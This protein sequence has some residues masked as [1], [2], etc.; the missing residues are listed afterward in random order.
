M[1]CASCEILIE[2]EFKK[3]DGVKL[4]VLSQGSFAKGAL[5]ML[6]FSLGTLPARKRLR[7]SLA[8]IT[9]YCYNLSTY[10]NRY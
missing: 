8:Y 7:N 10:G 6:A 2:R 3:I 1:S 9:C 4:Y 5:T